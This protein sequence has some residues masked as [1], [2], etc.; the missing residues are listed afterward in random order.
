MYK[1]YK[2]QQA[3]VAGW[4][5]R[6]C[7]PSTVSMHRCLPRLS[8]L[9]SSYW[10]CSASYFHGD[11]FTV[12]H[13]VAHTTLY[14]C[15]IVIITTVSTHATHDICLLLLLVYT[16]VLYM[17]GHLSSWF[18]HTYRHMSLCC[19][20]TSTCTVTATTFSLVLFCCSM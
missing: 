18:V 16:W 2:R 15:C 20:L 6:P 10:T 9:I 12:H 7:N 8:H 5:G 17:T 14:G 13:V 1:R 3:V 4:L 19:M 11:G